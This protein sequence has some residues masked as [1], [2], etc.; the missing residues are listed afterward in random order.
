M[1]QKIPQ[2]DAWAIALLFLS[3]MVS[4]DPV[5]A[6]IVPDA[7]LP[8][9]SAVN[10]EAQI[11]RI[12][13]GTQT[14]GNLFHSFREFN[15]GTGETAHFE[16]S[17]GIE[18]IITR[19]TGGNVSSIDGLIRAN[20]AANLF[21]LNPNGITF[22]ENARLDIGGSFFGS[23]AE[24]LVFEDGR[25]YSAGHSA[26]E[27]PL[28]SIN[29]PVGLQFGENSGGIVVEGMGFSGE[30]PAEPA[31]LGVRP[32]NAIV[33]VGG[34]VTFSGGIVTA[35]AGRI[36]IGSVASGDVNLIPSPVGWQLAYP[37]PETRLGRIQ[38]ENRASV[39]IPHTAEGAGGGIQV[40]GETIV[41]DRSQIAGAA[42][43]DLP[44]PDVS[45][46]ASELEILNGGR[47]QTLSFGDGDGGEVTVNADSILLN[48]FAPPNSETNPLEQF[49]NSRISSENFAA[50]NGG[51]VRVSAEEL[52]AIDGGQVASRVDETATGNG[53]R[54]IVN[55]ANSLTASG[56]LPPPFSPL[57]VSGIDSLSLG[58]GNGGD[59]Q[60][61]IG[62]LTL[63]EG[64]RIRSETQ[65][66][67]RGG[68]IA[69]TA[70]ESIRLTGLNPIDPIEESAII[71]QTFGSNDSGN[72]RV[73]APFLSVREGALVSSFV[74]GVEN[75]PG[76]G[77]GNAGNIQ[78]AT[79]VVEIVGTG[80]FGI[81][82]P[83][84]ISSNTFGEGNA[85]NITVETERLSLREGGTLNTSVILAPV[86]IEPLPGAGRGR[87]GTLNVNASESIEIV[88]TDPSLLFPSSLGTATFAEGDAGLTQV[89][90]PSLVVQGGSNL[91]SATIAT[92]NAGNTI[93]NAAEIL[94]EGTATD[95]SPSQIIANAFIPN[96]LLQLAFS[97]PPFPTGDTGELIVNT[98]RLTVRDG[99]LVGVQHDGTGNAGNLQIQANN[100]LLDRDGTI[101]ATTATGL[102]GDISLNVEDSLQLDDG[103]LTVAALGGTGN[104]GNLT[105]NAE[106]IVALDRS[107][108]VANSVG[109]NGGKVAIA[110]T[111]L[112]LSPNSRITASS[113]L[114][115]DG[116]VTVN[117]PD[118]DTA[119]GLLELTQEAIDIASLI[120]RNPCY[121][122]RDS[123][124]T[125]VGREGLPPD[126]RQ[127]LEGENLWEDWRTSPSSSSEFG[128]PNSEFSPLIEARGWVRHP[129]GTIEL[130]ASTGRSTSENLES[131]LFAPEGIQSTRCGDL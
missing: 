53:G 96:P 45:I 75:R 21:L 59:I 34:D 91:G 55:I 57:L 129:N 111:G 35:P 109:G 52:T 105:L 85:G 12:T 43:G 124:F 130:V 108:I 131:Q 16:N 32:G 104:G 67:G 61:E 123:S 89:T 27:D 50:G 4:I 107:A 3:S 9:P 90:T 42:F 126:N 7:T 63:S 44:G 17:L 125:I 80:L 95:G 114:G 127:A 113:Q 86:F 112:L 84:Q 128:I 47:I 54:L 8:E 40:R 46:N 29:V 56:V 36:E 65:G 6:Q 101:A 64:G 10:L 120:D 121:Q 93:V 94:V 28:L 100:V 31:G 24:S 81:D 13:G 20:G 41:V 79:E 72:I 5:S 87:G 48:G 2:S 102:G 11:Q 106:T 25:F 92:G 15:V 76:S 98:D 23:T 30:F 97:L 69:V 26:G 78:I 117:T 60:V 68:E 110:A 33:L 38:L 116:V 14:G 62:T 19:V 66:T 73:S 122:S 115:V 99:G 49:P 18:N 70:S 82:N 83:S 118:I 51:N 22:G 74:F 37:S 103:F 77:T 88:G 71:S 39:W 58:A 1:S 119:A